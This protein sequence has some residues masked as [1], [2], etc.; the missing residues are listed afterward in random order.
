MCPRPDL[1]T[2]RDFMVRHVHTLTPDVR[3]EDAVSFLEKHAVSNAPVLAEH[4]DPQALVG[5][6]SERDCLEHLSND[7][8]YERSETPITVRMMMKRHPICV[9]PSADLFTLATVF[10]QQGFR[11]LPVVEDTHLIGIVSRRD[12]L[13]AMFD[14][15]KQRRHDASN[16]HSPPDLTEIANLRFIMR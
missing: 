13:Q 14:F 6:L 1:P 12:V 11:H 2:A 8:F 10:Y 7:A 5:F 9:P 16:E 4:G 3:L 15:W